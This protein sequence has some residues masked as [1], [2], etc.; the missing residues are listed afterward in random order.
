MGYSPWRDET[1]SLNPLLPI[2]EP[3]KL[4][5]ESLRVRGPM[6]EHQGTWKW[7][8]AGGWETSHCLPHPLTSSVLCLD[9]WSRGTPTSRE[10]RHGSP[11][12]WQIIGGLGPGLLKGLCSLWSIPVH[13][14]LILLASPTV[15]APISVCPPREFCQPSY[16]AWSRPAAATTLRQA[17]LREPHC[18][19][20]C[21]RV[22]KTGPRQQRSRAQ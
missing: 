12:G 14:P 20:A 9:K 10:T 11:G 21:S 18:G 16:V 17:W 1:G 13:C 15:E 3:R 8:S 4:G 19:L 2:T 5:Q 6:D 7:L 22:G